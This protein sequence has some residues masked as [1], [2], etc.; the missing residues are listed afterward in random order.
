LLGRYIR[1]PAN[2][3]YTFRTN[4]DDGSKLYIGP[5][6][7]GAIALVNN[8][9]LHGSQDRDGAITLNAG[10][11]P[12][13]ITFFERS[14]GESMTVS[15]KTPFTGGNFVKIPD[16]VFAEAPVI[17]G[18]PPLKPSNLKAIATSYK[19]IE[20]RWNDNST[21]E[22]G[23]EILRSVHPSSG[24]VAITK[25]AANTILY[26]D[27]MVNPNTAYY[28]RIRAVN[29]FGESAYDR[30]EGNGVNYAYY[31]TSGLSVLP[32]FSL[33]NPV[34]TGR[35]SSFELGMENRSDNFQLK[36]DGF[37]TL[38]AS[39]TYTFY[40]ASDDGSKLYIGGYSEANLVVNNDGLHGA[41]ERSGTK[42]LAAG[43]YPIT[44]TFF[45]S[46]GGEVLSAS[47]SG[48]GLSKQAIPSSMLGSPYESAKTPPLP[49]TPAA[50]TNLLASAT[51]AKSVAITW[52]DNGDGEDNYELYRSNNTNTNYTLIATLPSNSVSFQDTGLFSNSI[53][54]YKVKAV[55]AGGGSASNE[56][57]AK[58]SNNKP[59]ITSIENQYIRFGTQLQLSL[60]AT[61]ADPESVTLQ[62]F[63]LPS[64]GSFTAGPDGTG[65][66][67][68][69]PSTANQ[70]TYTITVRAADQ[71]N[72][73]ESTTFQLVVSDNHNP[74]V[75]D[76]SNISMKENGTA[77][78]TL[79]ATDADPAAVFKWSFKGLP[80]FATL[81]TNEGVAQI[82][83][84]PSYADANTYLIEARV[85]DEKNGFDTTS[86]I[87]TVADVNVDKTLYINFNSTYNA[88]GVWNNLSMAPVAGAVRTGLKDDFGSN[89]TCGIKVLSDWSANGGAFA[90][91]TVTGTNSGVYPDV[92]MRT[93]WFAGKIEQAF[94]LTGLDPALIYN[95]KFFGSKA[96]STTDHTTVYTIN[97]ISASLNTAN[98]TSNTVSLN[99]IQPAA[100]STITIRIRNASTSANSYINAMV[101]EYGY[102]DGSLP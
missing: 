65:T 51:S 10:V 16:S 86:F 34:K 98:N 4:S 25:T 13:A 41:Q 93:G 22:S 23:F 59:F 28:Y 3:D 32:D 6:S 83:F 40:T 12:I 43:T 54:Y 77:Q 69:S 24:F 78:V 88:G 20:L 1:I 36:F 55:N 91:G 37:I 53:F 81:T 94:Q 100:D 76:A 39:G 68:F 79:T 97:G 85:Q 7:H 57:S 101:V 90:T 56:D 8:D 45:E 46:A 72:G 15:W 99:G 82:T 35:A 74:A 31:E 61:D 49:G 2:G 60:Q 92:V 30:S 27:T 50:P 58:T 96:G 89:T 67:T 73:L 70:G 11:Y 80:S 87:L 75:T 47:I 62:A 84:A 48:P 52:T 64:F 5:Y 18:Q 63:H 26:N 33:L 9:G 14:G 19:N 95:L 44:V 29:Q 17:N 21:D 38:P 66:L 102:D 71:N 42:T